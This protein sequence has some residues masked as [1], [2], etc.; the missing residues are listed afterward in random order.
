MF[1][2]SNPFI[3]CATAIVLFPFTI[4][5][6]SAVKIRHFLYDAGILRFYKP[7]IFTISVGNVVIGGAGK[8]PVVTEIAKSLVKHGRKTFVVTRGYGRNS[9][10]RV[11]VGPETPP[12]QSGDEPL[13]IFRK[14]GVPVICDKNRAAAVRDNEGKFDSVVLDDAF[15]H[16]KIKKDA[17]IV[18]V[19]QNRFLG[20]GLLLPSGILRDCVS[21]MRACDILILTKINPALKDDLR[22]KISYLK[23]FKKPLYLSSYRYS[24]I[25]NGSCTLTEECYGSKNLSLFC[26]IAEPGSF[27]DFFNKMKVVS[28]HAFRDHSFYGQ[29]FESVLEIMKNNSDIIVTTYKD[30][31][32]LSVERIRKYNIFY[33]DFD[34]VFYDIDMKETDIYE[35]ISGSDN[36]RK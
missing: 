13:T 27:F 1:F 35:I 20:N 12:E 29:S 6:Y 21:R 17:D 36:A 9:S 11:E 22:K 28:R 23:K 16:R 31:V 2:K 32:K 33:L 3:L 5:Y 4:L 7:G 34:T 26:G 18:L 15:Q 8:T 19:D 24:G 14:T 25:H 10:G 30:F